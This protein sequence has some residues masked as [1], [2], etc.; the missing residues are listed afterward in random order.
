MSPNELKERAQHVLDGSSR[1][2]V[3]DARAFAEAMIKML[4][5]YTKLADELA[6]VESRCTDLEGDRKALKDAIQK[7]A[8]A[9]PEARDEAI[10]EAMVAVGGMP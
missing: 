5:D 8:E 7:I 6:T 10:A 2:Y 9:S 3:A 1:S 4:G